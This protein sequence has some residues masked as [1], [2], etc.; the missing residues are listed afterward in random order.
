[1][2]KPD[3]LY[4]CDRKQKCSSSY[5]CK[6]LECM[7]TTDPNHALNGPCEN[8]EKS[9]RF[10]RWPDGSYVEDFLDEYKKLKEDMKND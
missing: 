1:M 4:L 9:D 7:H 5:Y 3:I 10:D 6:T 2:K 8:P